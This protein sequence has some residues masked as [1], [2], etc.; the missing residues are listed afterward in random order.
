MALTKAQAAAKARGELEAAA[1]T[2]QPSAERD[3]QAEAQAGYR[4]ATGLP[5]PASYVYTGGLN[6]V[7]VMLDGTAYEFRAHEPVHLP[8]ADPGLDKHPDF[9]RVA[10]PKAPE[11]GKE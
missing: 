9:K 7:V 8:H 10:A 4:E 2:A 3:L 6:A 1:D 5:E 11:D